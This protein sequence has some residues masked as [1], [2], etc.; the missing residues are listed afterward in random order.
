MSGYRKETGKPPAL[1]RALE[2]LR[3]GMTAMDVSIATSNS[4]STIKQWARAA[5]IPVREPTAEQRRARAAKDAKSRAGRRAYNMGI[6]LRG[7]ER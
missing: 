6:T 3:K 5:G 4:P 1:E 2:L 7:R